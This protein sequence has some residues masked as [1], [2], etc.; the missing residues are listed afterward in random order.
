MKF[1]NLTLISGVLLVMVLM[2]TITNS[3]AESISEQLSEPE[4]RARGDEL[5][6]KA[7]EHLA[8]KR[9]AKEGAAAAAIAAKEQALSQSRSRIVKE[10]LDGMVDIPGR[11]YRMGKTEVTQAEWEA[12]MGSNPS[13]FP[14]PDHPVETVSW[15]DANSFVKTLNSLPEIKSAGITFRLPSVNEWVYACLAGGPEGYGLLANGKQGTAEQLAV[16]GSKNSTAPVA[17]KEPNAWG[18]YDMHGNVG[19]W[20]AELT[21]WDTVV[22]VGGS[23]GDWGAEVY[24]FRDEDIATATSRDKRFRT[25]GFRLCANGENHT[26]TQSNLVDEVSQRDNAGSEKEAVSPENG[27]GSDL[28]KT[29]QESILNGG[30]LLK[31]NLKLF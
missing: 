27:Q 4:L 5:L 12:I 13:A 18:L 23:Y 21:Q 3:T 1:K 8:Q 6:K 17:S 15:D 7:V 16:C 19:E 11:S 20:T 25:I 26:E 30:E 10:I 31:R 28:K 22:V 14:F 29:I 2:L 9:K 24:Y